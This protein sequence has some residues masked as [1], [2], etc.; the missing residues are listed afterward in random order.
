[1]SLGR[2][3]ADTCWRQHCTLVTVGGPGPAKSAELACV[4]LPEALAAVGTTLPS[5]WEACRSS[6][7]LLLLSRLEACVCPSSAPSADVGSLSL[8]VHRQ[9]THHLTEQQWHP[10]AGLVF[11][12]VL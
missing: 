10:L 2:R 3:L 8:Y 7:G 9:R 1:M 5:V 4:M 11:F 6:V 12:G